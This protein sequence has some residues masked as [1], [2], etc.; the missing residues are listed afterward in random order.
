MY[1]TVVCV[2]EVWF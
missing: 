1:Y 2:I